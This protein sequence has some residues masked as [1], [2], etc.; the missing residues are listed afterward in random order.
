MKGNF[1]LP[2]YRVTRRVITNDGPGRIIKIQNHKGNYFYLVE[3][4]RDLF[5]D[6]MKEAESHVYFETDIRYE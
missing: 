6:Q 4:D 1:K 5:S 2:K 3:L